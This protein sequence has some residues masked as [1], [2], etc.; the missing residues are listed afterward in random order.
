M[1]TLFIHGHRFTFKHLCWRLITK[2]LRNGP[3]AHFP[4]NPYHLHHS[5]FHCSSSRS[6]FRSTHSTCPLPG[7]RRDRGATI[8]Y[9][10]S[11]DR[12]TTCYYGSG[13]SV[14]TRTHGVLTTCSERP[15]IGRFVQH[16]N[17]GVILS[18][19]VVSSDSSVSAPANGSPYFSA[20]SR[21]GFRGA[22]LLSAWTSHSTDYQRQI[23]WGV[24][25]SVL[26]FS[27]DRPRSPVDEV[28][29]WARGYHY[30]KVA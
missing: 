8:G 11:S 19:S 13:T 23:C 22:P 12:S 7:A 9:R 30:L 14:Q 21:C 16:Q 28:P 24:G 27:M 25:P 5:R 15:C 2:I 10:S 3:K 29:F 6:H 18:S 1:C 4:F 20:S 17:S 26:C